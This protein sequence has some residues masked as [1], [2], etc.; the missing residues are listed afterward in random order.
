MC[1][2]GL[3]SNSHWIHIIPVTACWNARKIKP[4]K[5]TKHGP[6]INNKVRLGNPWTGLETGRRFCRLR[7]EWGE[8]KGLQKDLMIL[9]GLDHMRLPNWPTGAPS[10]S[11]SC[12]EEKLRGREFKLS[13]LAWCIS[14]IWHKVYEFSFGLLPLTLQMSVV[15]LILN[16]RDVA[17]LYLQVTGATKWLEG[18]RVQPPLQTIRCVR[19]QAVLENPFYLA[20]LSLRTWTNVN[21]PTHISIGHILVAVL[22]CCLKSRI[23]NIS[24]SNS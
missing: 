19:A 8:G 24:M 5:Q 3:T 16:I 9:V 14:L 15:H 23:G 1:G 6:K 2:K 11:L 20:N 4:N 13:L 10:S 21:F 22:F 12:T 7:W 17:A 18:I